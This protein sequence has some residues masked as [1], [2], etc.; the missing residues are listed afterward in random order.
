MNKPN[1]NAG[2]T[3]FILFFGLALIE[4]IQKQNWLEAAIFLALGI[5]S[6]WADRKKK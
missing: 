4:A 1:F 3:I 5:V 6:F 2:I